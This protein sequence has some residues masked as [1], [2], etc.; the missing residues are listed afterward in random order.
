MAMSLAYIFYDISRLIIMSYFI[1]GPVSLG[2]P[3]VFVVLFSDDSSPI[4]YT[5]TIDDIIGY[6]SFDFVDPSGISVPLALC[7]PIWR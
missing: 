6:K 5:P 1:Q 4:K 2:R 3:K 7:C